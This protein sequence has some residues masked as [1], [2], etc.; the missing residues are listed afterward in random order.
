LNEL[1]DAFRGAL[2]KEYVTSDDCTPIRA[3]TRRLY[4][5]LIRFIAYLD[6]TPDYRPNKRHTKPPGLPQRPP[7]PACTDE[8]KN[9]R[10][11]KNQPRTDQR[12]FDCTYSIDFTISSTTFFA[13]PNTIIVLSM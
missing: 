2:E 1:Q 6:S 11:D 10:T 4:P 7:K 8:G 9:G 12:Q 13:S 5:A 3:L